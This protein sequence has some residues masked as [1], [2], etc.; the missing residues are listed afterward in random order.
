VATRER[1]SPLPL[2]LEAELPLP[3]DDEL[4]LPYED[5]SPPPLP[6]PYEDE[7][8]EYEPEEVEHMLLHSEPTQTVRL[9]LDPNFVDRYVWM[10]VLQ[11]DSTMVSEDPSVFATT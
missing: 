7:P 4:P 9:E 11:E 2:S 3:Y 8:P 1:R 6:L 10:A 5:E